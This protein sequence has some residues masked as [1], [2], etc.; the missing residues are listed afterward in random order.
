MSDQDRISPYDVNT[1]SSRQVMRKDNNKGIISWSNIK[2]SKLTLQHCIIQ[3]LHYITTDSIIINSNFVWLILIN[4]QQIDIIVTI[5][6]MF[7]LRTLKYTFIFF[8]LRS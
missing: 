3:Q 5:N 2:F 8:L 4:W 1:I 6:M 7:P